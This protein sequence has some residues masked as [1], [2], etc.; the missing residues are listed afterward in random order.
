MADNTQL[1]AGTGGDTLRDKDRA[2]TKTPIVGIDLGIGTGTESLMSGSMPVTGTFWQTTQPVSGTFWQA[3]Q[4]VSLAAAV[5]ATQSGSWSVTANAGTNLNTSALALESGGNLATIAAGTPALGQALAAASVP[6]VLTL[7]QMAALTP[8]ST[9]GV[10]GTFWQATQPVSGTF[11][12]ATQPV[13]GTVGATQSGSWSVTANAGTNLNTSALALETGGNLATIATRTPALGQ[14]LAAASVPVVLTAAQITTL[15]PPSTVGVTG[16]FWQTTQPV[17]IAATVGVTQSGTWTNTVTQATAASLNATVVGTGTL[18]VQNT[19]AT[20]AGTNLIG[21]VSGGQQ[22]ANVYNG[23]TAVAPQ[24]AAI[25]SS[26]S[27]ATTIVSAV[28]GKK[29]YVLRWSLSANGNVNVNWQS[30][31]TTGNATGL[32]YLTQYATAGGAYCPAGI[33]ATTAGEALDINLSASV[34]V[35]GELTYVQF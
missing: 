23:T 31:T 34:A 18:A 13:S 33:F 19:A 32:H 25:T 35:G 9:V 11:W 28:A 1:S 17:S 3:T 20:P 14:A 8:L 15:T 10:T 30:H 5:A 6:V 29:V 24:Y 21:Q 12:Q 22:I 2:G 27:G 7:A 4:P 26:S 16:T